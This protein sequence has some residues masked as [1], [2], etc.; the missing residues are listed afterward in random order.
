MKRINKAL[1]L[2]LALIMV[3]SLTACG[4][5]EAPAE[6]PAEAPAEK[7]TW[8]LSCDE[9][10]DSFTVGILQDMVK[11]VSDA[12]NGNF[13]L[14]LF[15]D[16]LLGDYTAVFDELMLG[17]VEMA[18]Q[19]LP[20][21]YDARLGMVFVPYLF[22]N[23]EEAEQVFGI[24][25]NTNAILADILAGYKV[26][27]F[28]TMPM[29]F[30]G[31]G[32]VKLDAN[33]ADPTAA[34]STLVRTPGITTFQ[35]ALQ[36]MGYSTVTINYS[37]LFTA[38]QTGVCDAQFGCTAEVNYKSFR[39]VIKYYIPYNAMMENNV[40]MVSEAAWEALPAEYQEVL[41][42]AVEDAITAS[43]AG[44]KDLDEQYIAELTNAGI[45]VVELTAEELTTIAE[46]VREETWAGLEESL[47]AEVMDAIRAD[48]AK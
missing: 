24:G 2:I 26:K 48:L 17:S 45:E 40:A 23:C 25:S 31:V 32:A 29:G 3:F 44:T 46:H 19:S 27:S 18:V 9:S 13:T 6:T 36:A 22:T 42:K 15:S 38:L 47:T 39:D 34:K 43:F 14:E 35:V 33:Y 11:Q 10:V 41:T 4:S 28:G 30:I 5:S 7:I 37:D 12:T 8:K 21:S 1:A 16:S 20:D